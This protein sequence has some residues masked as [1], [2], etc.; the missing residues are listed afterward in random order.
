MALSFGPFWLDLRTQ[1]LRLHGEVLALEPKPFAILTHLVENRD[2]VVTKD[3]LLDTLWPD[4]VVSEWALTS[5]VKG[6]RKALRS[7]GAHESEG[8]GIKTVHGRGFRFVG[9]VEETAA[10]GVREPS[11]G[12][13]DPPEAAP[14]VET[15]FVGREKELTELD[16]LLDRTTAGET[17][18]AFVSGPAGIGKSALLDTFVERARAT[19]T[20]IAIGQSVEQYGGGEPYLPVLEA[21]SRLARSSDPQSLAQQMERVAPTWLAHVPSLVSP[22]EHERLQRRA[23]DFTRDRMLREMSDLL[24]VLTEQQPLL[25]VLEDI[26]WSDHATLDLIAYVAQRRSRARVLLLGTY[27]PVEVRDEGHPLRRVVQDARA[28]GK[29]ADLV[30][31]PLD[32]DAVGSYLEHRLPEAPIDDAIVR[33]IHDRTDGQPLFLANVI[34]FALQNDFLR[35]EAGRWVLEAAMAGQV[36]DGLRHMVERQI[37]ALA[38]EDR[39]A[40]EAAAAAGT[41][42]SVASLAAALDHDLPALEERCEALAW[43][44]QFLRDVGVEEWPDGTISGSYRFVHSMYAEV[45]YDRVASARRVTLHRRLGERKEAAFGSRTAEVS[46]ELALHFERARDADRAVRYRAEAASVATARHAHREAIE[47]I[48]AA[49]PLVPELPIEGRAQRELELLLRLVGPVRSTRRFPTE[50]SQHYLRARELARELGNPEEQILL[51][52]GHLGTKIFRGQLSEA[53]A[54]AQELEPLLATTKSTMARIQANILLASLHNRDGE[55]LRAEGL[56]READRLYAPETHFEH[57]SVY[58]D[59]DPGVTIQIG[60]A[61]AAWGQGFP[62][63]AT[64]F[65]VEALRRAERLEHPLSTT[66]AHTMMAMDYLQ[67]GD[68][69]SA[70]PHVDTALELAREGGFETDVATLQAAAGWVQ[71]LEG[72]A[73]ASVE[74]LDAAVRDHGEALSL[75]PMFLSLRGIALA[76]QSRL[77]EAEADFDSA[78]ELARACGERALLLT[79]LRTRSSFLLVVDTPRGEVELENAHRLALDVGDRMGALNSATHLA[80]LYIHK[81]QPNQARKVLEP[82]Y[83]SFDEGLEMPILEEARETLRLAGVD[84]KEAPTPH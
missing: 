33:Q 81:G 53:L 32:R 76:L 45:L 26:H 62:A 35:R 9:H 47:H 68:A 12:A 82:I 48:E 83:R 8:L 75:M 17:V 2:R 64:E 7:S 38:A 70:R 58:G 59:V 79:V 46:G 24:E 29:A 21:L 63:R 49:L 78:V 40:L 56:L 42:F 61:S 66:F 5:A 28:R 52:V 54:T 55:P 77:S 22:E 30:L 6:A 16:R 14:T 27:R 11:N 18:A 84:T 73:D 60:L 71:L 31:E 72:N 37:D 13:S 36:P 69:T 34:D 43:Q 50:E 80:Q 41:D 15:G 19:G 44:G 51:L 65:H 1:E 25:L 57:I 4:T 74:I 39:S 10:A 20:R 67:H 23:A 3:E